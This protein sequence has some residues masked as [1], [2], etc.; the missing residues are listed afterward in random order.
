MSPFSG[1]LADRLALWGRSGWLGLQRRCVGWSLHSRH[2][3]RRCGGRLGRSTVAHPRR[4]RRPCSRGRML[5][6]GR[7][8]PASVCRMA[9]CKSATLRGTQRAGRCF[10]VEAGEEERF[11]GVDIADAGDV[12]L[13]EECGFDWLLSPAERV[14][15]RL[16]REIVRQRLRAELGQTLLPCGRPGR[17]CR[18]CGH[19]RSAVGRR[20]R[21]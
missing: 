2:R 4:R 20:G 11:V 6:R 12:A 18:T 19:R 8:R 7:L 5:R 15:H 10:G 1:A 3:V 13:V 9:A 21:G 16:N 14:P 17:W